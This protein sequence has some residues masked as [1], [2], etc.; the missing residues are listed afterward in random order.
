VDELLAGR[1][2]TLS[3]RCHDKRELKRRHI[4][5]GHTALVDLLLHCVLT[6][7]IVLF[8]QALVDMKLQRR[9]SSSNTNL[10]SYLENG[11][12]L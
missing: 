10:L 4:T 6:V 1:M 11:R 3:C 2:R 12:M 5:L 9:D 8:T 7:T